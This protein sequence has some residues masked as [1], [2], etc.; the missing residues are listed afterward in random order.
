MPNTATAAAIA[1]SKLLLAAVNPIGARSEVV[2]LDGFR[3][4]LRTAPLLSEPG[5]EHG[6]EESFR[7]SV[8]LLNADD[9]HALDAFYA[10]H[11]SRGVNHRAGTGAISPFADDDLAFARDHIEQHVERL[12]VRGDFES[13]IEAY[14]YHVEVL[15]LEHI[16]LHSVAGDELH[17]L[18]QLLFLP[19]QVIS[20]AALTVGA[21]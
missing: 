5:R 11:T 10:P 8:W 17:E 9:D 15:A 4:G 20:S 1:S 18:A 12:V 21:A 13:I 14:E 2:A 3:G 6:I 19:W 16:A 7:Q